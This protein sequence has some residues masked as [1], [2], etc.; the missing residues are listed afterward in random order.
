VR[1]YHGLV[2]RRADLHQRGRAG[3]SRRRWRLSRFQIHISARLRE[4]VVA[5]R[6][7]VAV[8]TVR[9]HA[10]R[11]IRRCNS[12]H[13]NARLE[14]LNGLFQAARA[15][16]RGYRNTATFACIIY[17]IGAPIIELLGDIRSI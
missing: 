12:G 16:A 6:L 17:L 11:I 14:A 9:R 7:G 13:S 10:A 5:K 3:S 4:A 15:R 2:P 8:E 1:R